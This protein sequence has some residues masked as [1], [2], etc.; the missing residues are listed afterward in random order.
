MQRINPAPLSPATFNSALE[1]AKRAHLAGNFDLARR[2]YVNILAYHPHEPSP[3]AML[4]EL[5]LREGK[6]MS[7]RARLE[8]LI[9]IDPGAREMRAALANVLEDLGDVTATT[10]FYR[11]ETE[12]NPAAIEGWLKLASAH[13]TAGR[14]QDAVDAYRRI[15]RNWPDAVAGYAGIVMIDAGQLSW[16]EFGRLEAATTDPQTPIRDRISGYFA[17]GHVYENRRDYDRAFAA[18]STGNRLKLESPNPNQDPPEWLKLLLNDAPAFSSIGEA[19]RLHEKFVRETMKMFTS[20]YLA[21]FAGG[22]VPSRAPIFIVGMP[23][24]GSTLLEQILSS[25]PDV[26]GLGETQALSRTFRLQISAVRR[27]PAAA[28]MFYERLGETYLEAL[29]ELGWDG[30]RRVIDKMLGNYINIG[31]IHLAFPEAVI[32][33]STRDA[34]DTCLSCFRQLFARQ[35]EAS[36]ELGAIG[37]QYRL[38]REMMEHWEGVLPTRVIH[39][40]H[41]KLVSDPERQIRTLVASCRL[42]WNDLCLQ[43]HNNQRTVRTASVSQVRRPV[44]DV[45][46]Q[47]WRHYEKHLG[48][49][50][51]SLGRYAPPDI[52]RS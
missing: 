37:R 38:Y 6:L 27:N 52:G 8:R 48:P 17:L 25:H 34:V 44:S 41:E 15:L 30:R 18:F 31:I 39:V 32:I 14:N 16:D 2:L 12:R 46:V 45:A 43:P 1:E 28:G 33:H 22:G 42:Q 26:Q 36:F 24:S 20:N 3:Q 35:N 9:A 50:F 19:E 11:E 23:R 13:R 47:R 4:A 5:D 40:E 10:E 51:V 49:L 29:R 21:K 7:A